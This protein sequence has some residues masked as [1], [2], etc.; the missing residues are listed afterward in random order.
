M[1]KDPEERVAWRRKHVSCVAPS[2]DK[3]MTFKIQEYSNS[4]LIAGCQTLDCKND[5][6]CD[7]TDLVGRSTDVRSL[8]VARHAH[9]SYDAILHNLCVISQCLIVC[10]TNGALHRR[11]SDYNQTTL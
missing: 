4:S 10:S 5:S 3:S 11:D 2:I 9:E 8:L 7:G 1:W 6:G